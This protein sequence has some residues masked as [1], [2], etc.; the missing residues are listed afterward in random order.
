MRRMIFGV[1]V[2]TEIGSS[3]TLSA[4]TDFPVEN[5]SASDRRLKDEPDPEGPHGAVERGLPPR[6]AA[7]VG[8]TLSPGA[9][10][11][12]FP[13]HL[14]WGKIMVG[15]AEASRSAGCHA[16]AYGLK[17]CNLHIVIDHDLYHSSKV[18][19]GSQGSFL[20]ILWMA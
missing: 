19:R 15:V 3:T 10:P 14:R 13:E 4:Q 7:G 1:W 8:C 20:C 5:A 9:A 16:L 11:S 6:G 12:S 18:T 2:A 17:T